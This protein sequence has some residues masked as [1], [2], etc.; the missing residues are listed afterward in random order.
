MTTKAQQAEQQLPILDA[1]IQ[2][3]MKPQTAITPEPSIMQMMDFCIRNG[4]ASGEN[5]NAIEMLKELRAMQTEDRKL[6]A[7]RAFDEAMEAAQKAV[8]TVIPDT[9][10]EQTKKKYASFKALDNEIR[11]I[12]KEN[13]LT[14]SFNAGASQNP[15]EILV[16]CRVS[17]TK[18]HEEIYTVP[19]ST[20]M[21]GPKGG[22][23]MSKPLSIVSATSYGRSTL[24]KL[25]FNIPIAEPEASAGKSLDDLNERLENMRDGDRASLNKV[26]AA[27]WAAAVEIGDLKSLWQFI[28]LRLWMCQS[29]NELMAEGKAAMEGV[30]TFRDADLNKAITA[31]VNTRKGELLK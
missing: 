18:G 15:D 8:K 29:V 4:G 1:D 7:K 26:Y 13:R 11:P 3:A 23:V 21:S 17:H 10:N 22:G 25:I 16:F 27:N 9:M 2:D 28:K 19:M 30:A 20:N 6:A 5:R 24:L 14:L 31:S 12:C